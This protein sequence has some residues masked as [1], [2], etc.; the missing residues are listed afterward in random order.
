MHYEFRDPDFDGLKCDLDRQVSGP[1]PRA[2]LQALVLKVVL[3]LMIA[4]LAIVA[5]RWL[6]TGDA[7]PALA[8]WAICAPPLTLILRTYINGSFEGWK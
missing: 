2:D 8:V 4:A 3:G 1:E 5:I 6:I 7:T